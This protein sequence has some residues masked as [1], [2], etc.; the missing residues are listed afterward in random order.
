MENHLTKFKKLPNT[1]QNRRKKTI[2]VNETHQTKVIDINTYTKDKLLEDIAKYE[3]SIVKLEKII[4][5]NAVD[6]KLKENELIELK[7]D[8]IQLNGLKNFLP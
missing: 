1:S 4:A 6:L 2:N 3:K 8:L 5:N 7:Q